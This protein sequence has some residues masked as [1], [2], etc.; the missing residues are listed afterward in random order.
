MVAVLAAMGVWMSWLH[1]TRVHPGDDRSSRPAVGG[2][3]QADNSNP[4]TTPTSSPSTDTDVAMPFDNEAPYNEPLTLREPLPNDSA[5]IELGR[6]L[7]HKHCASCHGI[8]GRGD[9]PAGVLCEPPPRDFRGKLHYQTWLGST[10]SEDAHAGTTIW[11]GAKH[12]RRAAPTSAM[13]GFMGKLQK[14]QV[15][16]ILAFVKQHHLGPWA[17]GPP[18]PDR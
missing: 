8:T 7:F 17:A 18:S 3:R 6:G 10:P 13:T 5:S 11:L 12:W 16:Q 9:G 15:L 4:A 14:V 1:T 2:P